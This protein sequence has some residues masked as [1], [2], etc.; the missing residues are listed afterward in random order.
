MTFAG[1]SSGFKTTSPTPCVRHGSSQGP[2]RLPVNPWTGSVDL[3]VNPDGTAAVDLPWG[4]P[5]SLGLSAAF[6][7]FWLIGRD[8]V[9]DQARPPL[10]TACQLPCPP[11]GDVRIVTLA[12]S[13]RLSVSQPTGWDPTNPGA[14]FN[15]IQQGSR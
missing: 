1:Q 13:V 9:V 4:V 12:K 15:A 8:Q 3:L 10:P 6:Y 7:H 14:P 5:S 11:S 2:S